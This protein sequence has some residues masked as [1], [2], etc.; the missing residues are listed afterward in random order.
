M[1]DFE[2]F[3]LNKFRKI[4]NNY[5]ENK[6]ECSKHSKEWK[7]TNPRFKLFDQT[8]FHAGD[9]ID[10][11]KYG[12]LPL[13]YVYSDDNENVNIKKEKTELVFKLYKNINYE[14]VFNTYMYMFNKFK[15]GIFVIIRDNKLLLFLPF[16]NAYYKNNWYKKT[17]F[18]IEEKKLL[19]TEDYNKIKPRLD[20][21]IIEFQKKYPDQFRKYKINL[22][23]KKWQANNCFFRNQ[24]PIYEGELTN[25]IYKNMLDELLKNR[26]IPNIEFFINN[27]D[28]PILKNDYTEP[29]EHLFDSDNIK[30]EKE[31]QFK[32]MAP[33]FS[34]SI[35]NKFADILI[36]TN[37]DWMMASN[38][39]YTADCSN[40]YHKNQIEKWNY[41]WSKKKNICIFRG[42]ATGCGI[43]INNNMRLKAA[44]I[45]INYSDILDAGITDWNAKPKKY[46]GHPIEVIDS[47]NFRFKLANK[48]NN[49]EKSNYKYILNIDGHV[50]AFRLS[51]ELSM[52]SVVLLVTSPY[53][54][55]FSDMLVPFIH[56]IPV[57]ADLEDL[58]DQINWCIE[59]DSKCKEIA[60]NAKLFFNKYLTKEGI[61]D[62]L[63]E[64]F[65]KIY[66]NKNFKNLL[67]IKF[68]KKN[69]AYISCFRDK[70]DGKR[71]KQRKI[72]IQLMSKLLKPYCNFHIYI[73][74]QSK[75]NEF[76][77][78]G[79]L[80]NIGYIISKSEKKFDHYI[81]SDIDTI[82]DYDLM[83]YIIKK[84]DKPI[85]LANRGTRYQSKNNKSG[86]PFLGALIS[87]SGKIFEKINGYPNNF[88]GWGGEDDAV[89]NRLSNNKYNSVY[90]PKKGSI[91]DFEES[92]DMSVINIETKIKSEQKDLVKY[93]KLYEDLKSWDSN[94][95]NKLNYN[96]IDRIEIN[97]YT[98]QIK[99]YLLKKKDE[100]KYPNWFP[101]PL[102]NYKSIETIVKNKWK[103]ISIEYL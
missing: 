71:E 26:K 92:L 67:D 68:S 38:K 10:I 19:E 95:I 28:F 53:K 101:K 6:D 31:Y 96:I 90:Y 57:R 46:M 99:V 87:F 34:K 35:T 1:Q 72:F 63:Q 22:D 58:I 12:L 4:K 55:W 2:I 75:D 36:P 91:I 69:I 70:G 47:T 85:C 48:I 84:T 27:R 49:I 45:S 52:N 3:S 39:F 88:W 42:G 20:K 44:N 76:F 51:S 73:I 16:S 86:K 32:K 17:Y 98:S 56:Y 93:E 59:N 24:Y 102:D 23:R 43:T 103:D 8:H 82:P 9:M 5:Y 37:D 30:I 80:K 74:E 100:I 89:I 11:N 62:Y 7:Q 78:I 25:N 66:S 15:K 33:I 60:H 41:D 21:S 40:T 29:Y 54:L 97:E 64:I 77:N 65:G 83:E 50:S 81:F 18:S 94:G 79:K 14:S 13:R 61:F